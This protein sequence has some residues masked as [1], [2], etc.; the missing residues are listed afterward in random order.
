MDKIK[1]LTYSVIALL[2][3]NLATIGFVISKPGGRHRGEPHEII[4]E[5]LRFDGNQQKE[6]E[7]LI[8]WHRTQ[9]DELDEKI[10]ET[11]KEL[12]AQLT[13]DEIEQKTKDSLLAALSMYQKQ[14][15]A[16]H[17]KHFQDIKKLCRKEQ[18]IEFNNLTHEL[19]NIFSQAPKRP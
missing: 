2:V 16:T 4:I 11:Q 3:L 10:R 5:K 14:I 12:Y 7:Q 17:F 13:Q 18:L 19:S 1:M 9:I 15:E 6:F 8:D